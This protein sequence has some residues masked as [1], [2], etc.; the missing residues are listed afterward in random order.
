MLLYLINTGKL[1][2]IL[3]NLIAVLLLSINTIHWYSL[4]I[5]SKSGHCSLNY[6]LLKAP[7]FFL[8]SGY[9]SCNRLKVN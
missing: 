8:F 3:C 5:I 9:I 1:K 7:D 6:L 2:K 4:N